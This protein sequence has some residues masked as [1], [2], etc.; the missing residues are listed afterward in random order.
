V[1]RAEAPPAREKVLTFGG[2]E[3]AM[4]GR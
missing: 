4:K 1:D 2:I 3:L